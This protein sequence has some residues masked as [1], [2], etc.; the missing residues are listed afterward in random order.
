MIR[1]PKSWIGASLALVAA[2]SLSGC[3]SCQNSCDPCGNSCN[4]GC[5]S[6]CC[7]NSCCLN[8]HTW[9][10]PAVPE[11]LPLG[12]TV[13]AHYHTMETNGEASDFIMHD[14]EFA[15]NT[16]ELTPS[17]R[18]HVAE[19]GARMRSTPFPVLIERSE[20]NSDPELDA[21]RRQIVAQVLYSMGNPDADQ[22]TIVAQ[23]YGKGLNSQEAE[24]DY[25]NFIYTRGGFGNGGFNNQGNFGGFG[26]GGGG[27]GGGIG[28]GR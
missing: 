12:S 5:G 3:I 15:G 14:H 7:W 26:V 16:A 23:A 27:G 25:Y 9:R 8:P 20:N 2:C 28:F 19:I 17:G 21:H 4:T 1:V 6:G 10:H 18:D 13:R 11:T 22:R 24:F